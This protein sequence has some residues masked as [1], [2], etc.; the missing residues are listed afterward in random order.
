MR[1]SPLT[2]RL[3][4][5]CHSGWRERMS[6]DHLV[7]LSRL[8]SLRWTRARFGV[9]QSWQESGT[10]PQA[11]PGGSRLNPGAR[12]RQKA[13]C[14]C[15]S[16]LSGP[17]SSRKHRATSSKEA[18]TRATSES[19]KSEG[20]AGTLAIMMASGRTH[21]ATRLRLTYI[22]YHRIIPAGSGAAVQGSDSSAP[23][24]LANHLVGARLSPGAARWSGQ[25][26]SPGL[27]E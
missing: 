9:C 26:K 3:C 20:G 16:D 11:R 25:S 27:S 15:A 8:R 13:T 24:S 14:S 10:S 17:A 4:G 7:H 19:E 18:L 6:S 21:L 1:S 22:E 23:W 5:C 12:Q 2:A